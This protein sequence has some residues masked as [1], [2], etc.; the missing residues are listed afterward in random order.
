[1]ILLYTFDFLCNK[2]HEQQIDMKS[3]SDTDL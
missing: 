3:K 2:D 1:M